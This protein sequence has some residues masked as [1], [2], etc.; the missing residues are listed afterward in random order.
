[1]G[2]F[3]YSHEQAKTLACC[4]LLSAFGGIM[5]NMGRQVT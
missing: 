1:M 2:L 5:S 4:L 3:Y